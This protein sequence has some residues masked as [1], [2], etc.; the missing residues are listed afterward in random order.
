MPVTLNTI[1]GGHV[2]ISVQT[3]QKYIKVNIRSGQ[4]FQTI[5][6]LNGGGYEVSS[7]EQKQLENETFLII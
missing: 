4:P 6:R 5:C 7:E 2:F 1:P 3:G